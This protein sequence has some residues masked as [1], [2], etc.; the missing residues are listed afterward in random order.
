MNQIDE[1]SRRFL[2]TNVALAQAAARWRGVVG[3]DTEFIR[4]NTFFAIPGL[5]QLA[6][7]GFSDLVDPIPIDD[8]APFENFLRD[9][10]TIVMHSCSEDLELLNSHLGVAPSQLF[11]TQIAYAFVSPTYSASYATLVDAYFDVTLDKGATRSN[12]LQRPLSDTQVHYAHLDVAY[13]VPLYEELSEQLELAG[14]REW[15]IEEMQQRCRYLHSD[16][17]QYYVGVSGAWRLDQRALGALR[18]LCSWREAKARTENVPRSKILK[19]EQLYAVAQL[20]TLTLDDLRALIPSASCKRYGAQLLEEHAAGSGLLDDLAT[21][22]KPFS[23]PENK[24]IKALRAVARER[25]EQLGLAPE[26]LARKR[27][28]EAY[29]RLAFD[30][31]RE[32]HNYGN[33]RAEL[34]GDDFLAIMAK[35]GARAAQDAP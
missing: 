17:Q 33:W 2:N 6:G 11:D 23:S 13:L 25:A 1:S 29:A 31:P 19:D 7:T 9:E 27:E 14:R 8:W 15:C 4:T 22:A 5:Y 24:L 35:G 20:P 16:P 3:F 21:L 28:V 26:L 34:V 10:S 18:A 30:T 32:L 12:W